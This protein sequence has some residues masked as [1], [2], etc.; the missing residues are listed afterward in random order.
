MQLVQAEPAPYVDPDAV[1]THISASMF[2][3]L[4]KLIHQVIE[5]SRQYFRAT[6]LVGEGGS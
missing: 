2:K 6:D 5:K 4:Q 3:C 1:Y